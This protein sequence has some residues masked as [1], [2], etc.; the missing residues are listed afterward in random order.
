MHKFE[1][2][3]AQIERRGCWFVERVDGDDG[4]LWRLLECTLGLSIL[5]GEM[6]K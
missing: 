1:S 5:Y 6:S 2:L 4:M 3:V